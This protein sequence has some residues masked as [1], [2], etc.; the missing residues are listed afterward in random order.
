[1][2]Y[3]SSL[4][5]GSSNL[6]TFHRICNFEIV[7]TIDVESMRADVESRTRQGSYS[8]TFFCGSCW[9]HWGRNRLAVD[10]VDDM[11][12]DSEQENMLHRD[13]G[14]LKAE[15][16]EDLGALLAQKTAWV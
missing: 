11:L 13:L 1:M 9:S 3:N 7:S 12:V 6:R 4:E 2:V 14:L 10:G 5:P 15:T 8:E 16:L